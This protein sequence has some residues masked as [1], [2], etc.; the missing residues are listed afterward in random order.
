MFGFTRNPTVGLGVAGIKTDS[1][2]VSE[3]KPITYVF[4]RGKGTSTTSEKLLLEEVSIV[5]TV[6]ESK[7]YR[8]ILFKKT[9]RL[10]KNRCAIK[11]TNRTNKKR[12]KSINGFK[13]KEGTCSLANIKG[14][15]KLF[16]TK[17]TIKRV[18]PIGS[19]I[20]SP[21]Q[22]AFFMLSSFQNR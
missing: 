19:R 11:P 7:R 17:S 4:S 9:S 8:G 14:R 15:V 22:N 21:V 16:T 12:P 5:S 10:N 6:S 20:N 3:T 2:L 13:K 18:I 1:L